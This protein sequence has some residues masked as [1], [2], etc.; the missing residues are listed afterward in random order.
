VYPPPQ[1]DLPPT[2]R[3]R[4][5]ITVVI[6]FR[7]QSSEFRVF[8]ERVCIHR[9]KWTFPR[10]RPRKNHLV[11]SFSVQSSEFTVHS[12]EFRV[13]RE[14]VCIYRP[15]WTF[16]RRR[17]RK[18]NHRRDLVQSSEFRV[19]SSEFRVQSLQGEGLYPPPQVD[20]PPTSAP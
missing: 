13:F 19:H 1:V 9:P 2:S 17:P 11:I 15:K 16:P 18:K 8:R 6:S 20:L 4:K 5:K 10:R 3:P 12:S 14:R 7:V